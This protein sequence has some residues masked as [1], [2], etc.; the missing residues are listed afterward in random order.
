MSYFDVV[1]M[2]DRPNVLDRAGVVSTRKL[3]LPDPDQEGRHRIP[4]PKEVQ[5]DWT[6]FFDGRSMT[7][8]GSDKPERVSLSAA[9]VKSHRS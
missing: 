4:D 7:F 8:P 3:N 2:P 1:F 6:D 9:P 5:F